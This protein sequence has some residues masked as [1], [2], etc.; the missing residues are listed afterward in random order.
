MSILVLL[1]KGEEP[2]KSIN[3]N[4]TVLM[5]TD[6]TE[7]WYETLKVPIDNPEL[8]ETLNKSQYTTAF[9]TLGRR[10]NFSR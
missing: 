7:S 6:M 2:F 3:Q 9:Y 4:N 8:I 10:F 1:T 5:P